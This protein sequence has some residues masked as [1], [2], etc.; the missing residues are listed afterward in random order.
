MGLTRTSAPATTPVSLAEAKAHLRVSSDAEDDLITALIQAATDRVD[1]RNGITNRALVT[2]TWEYTLDEFP[3]SDSAYIILPLPPVQS[4]SLITYIDSEGAEQTLSSDTYNLDNTIDP[5][6]VYLSYNQSWPSTQ[7]IE[8]AVTVTF[9]C[10]Y[11][12]ASDVPGALK[13]AILL[14]VGHLY[15][16]RENVAHSETYEVPQTAEYLIDPYRVVRF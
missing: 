15:T 6:R 4:I 2:Q 9:V 3:V 16:N 12:S 13:Q 1:G 14:T 5:A 7:G 8:N 10:G 11:G